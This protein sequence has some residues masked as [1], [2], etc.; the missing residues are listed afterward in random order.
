MLAN[1]SPTRSG[2]SRVTSRRQSRVVPVDQVPPQIATCE[3]TLRNFAGRLLRERSVRSVIVHRERSEVVVNTSCEIST[4][5]EPADI[6]VEVLAW[7]DPQQPYIYCIRAP[8]AVTGWRRALF[9]AGGAI[10]AALAA[11]GVI[12]P[13]LPTTPFVLLASY[14]LLRSSRHWHERL[15]RNRLFGGVLRDWYL[16]RGLRPHIRYKALAMLVLVVAASLYWGGLPWWAN[17]FLVAIAAFG[18]VYVWRLPDV[19]E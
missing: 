16:H 7:N 5:I 13:G 1:S 17:L 2:Q 12:L 4:T 15:L 10:S 18:A 3:T 11:L 9:L 8:Q 19:V 14:C 6:P